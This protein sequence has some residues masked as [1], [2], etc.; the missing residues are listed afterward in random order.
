[1]NST[2]LSNQ[3]CNEFY[4][5]KNGNQIL[6][7]QL[8]IQ[9]DLFSVPG[10][11]DLDIGGPVER[12]VWGYNE[13]DSYVF[14][15]NSFGKNC[16]FGTPVVATRVSSFADW[17]EENVLGVKSKKKPLNKLDN[18]QIVFVDDEDRKEGDSCSIPGDTQRGVCMQATKCKGFLEKY[19]AMQQE[20][21]FCGFQPHTTVCCP[22]T[23][24]SR[25]SSTSKDLRQCSNSFKN[26]RQTASGATGASK[27][28]NNKVFTHTA[29]IGFVK[30]SRVDYRCWGALI[31]EDF[32]VTTASCLS[33]ARRDNPKQVRLGNVNFG[34]SNEDQLKAVSKVIVH[35][36]YNSNTYYNDI[37]LLK[38]VSPARLTRNVVPACLWHSEDYVPFI[39]IVPGPSGTRDIIYNCTKFGDKKCE[40]VN[41][42]DVERKLLTLQNDNCQRYYKPNNVLPDGV[43]SSQM[44]GQSELFNS[45]DSC[46]RT[47]GALYQK[48][49]EEKGVIVPYIVGLYSYDKDCHKDNPAIFTRISSFINFITE[50]INRE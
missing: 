2:I 49:T 43:I 38:L 50:Q 14:G 17:I 6:D 34:L 15:V 3:A 26:L 36:L 1:M 42:L 37:A 44:C 11:C 45:T 23:L 5:K 33:Q 20:V 28:E 7:S 46:I 8:C 21:K 31:A 9:N 4:N 10:I 48:S 41:K 39:G 29:A 24:S 32:V 27:Y 12:K 40:A 13:Y 18:D 47:P 30:N 25:Q 19:R 16:G 22:S 35:P